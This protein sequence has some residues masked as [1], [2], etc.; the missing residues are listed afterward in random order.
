[1]ISDA[2][3]QTRQKTRSKRTPEKLLTDASVESGSLAP[4]SLAVQKAIRDGK[5]PGAVVLIG[6][7]D[8]VVYRRAFG[9]RALMPRKLPMMPTTIFD[10]ASLTKVIATT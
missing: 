10:I 4:I 5:C 7:A 8:S 1:M 9:Y 2:A 3:A 6:H